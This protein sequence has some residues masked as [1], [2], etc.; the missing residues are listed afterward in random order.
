M[1]PGTLVKSSVLGHGIVVKLFKGGRRAGCMEVV[2]LE[3]PDKWSVVEFRCAVGNTPP[4]KIEESWPGKEVGDLVRVHELDI[5]IKHIGFRVWGESLEQVECGYWDCPEGP[6]TMGDEE[7]DDCDYYAE[8]AHE[9]FYVEWEPRNGREPETKK[10]CLS[11]VL[12]EEDSLRGE[13]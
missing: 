8:V 5:E 12:R 10:V 6:A 7:D 13:A 2:F 3:G 9:V 4:Q 1:S 11:C